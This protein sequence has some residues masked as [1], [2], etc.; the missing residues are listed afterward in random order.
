MASSNTSQMKARSF[1]KRFLLLKACCPLVFFI[2]SVKILVLA[3]DSV[4]EARIELVYE[5]VQSSYVVEIGL[6]GPFE[7]YGA[8]HVF[9]V[10]LDEMGEG[11]A[12]APQQRQACERASRCELEVR[13][14]RAP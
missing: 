10:G 11:V 12:H 7:R 2:T 4:V 9:F 14:D 1:R 13:N 6:Y 5:I 3:H 8:D